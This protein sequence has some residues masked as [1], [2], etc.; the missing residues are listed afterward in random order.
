M[1]TETSLTA[2]QSVEV[3]EKM[4]RAN[5]NRIERNS[6]IPFLI[7]GYTTVLVSL[8]VFFLLPKIGLEANY[9]WLLIPVIGLITSFAIIGRMPK[10]KVQGFQLTSRFM[11]VLW[12]VLGINCL[13]CSFLGS[14][15]VLTLVTVII[16]SG[17]AITAFTLGFKSMQVTSILGMLIGYLL[18][19][20]DFGRYE[21]LVFAAAFLMMMIIPG[22][23]LLYKNNSSHGREQ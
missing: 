23:Y 13:L 14:N 2:Q 4:I 5:N 8:I 19:F 18:I 11:Q 16:G 21:V 3:I 20:M 22:H 12:T 10:E 7:W 17:A 9:F 6:A 1:N 15:L